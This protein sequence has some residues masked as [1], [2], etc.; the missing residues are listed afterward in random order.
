MPRKPSPRN[1]RDRRNR[2]ADRV[3]CEPLEARRVLTASI[4]DGILSIEG[5]AGDDTIT[6][7]QNALGTIVVTG[8]DG[9]PDGTEFTGVTQVF[10]SLGRG[11]D[12]FETIGNLFSAPP[13][14][15]IGLAVFGGGGNDT[16]IGGNGD[17]RLRGGNNRDTIFGMG[18]DDIIK[19]KRGHD[20]LIG[21]EGDDRLV[22]NAGNDEIHGSGGNDLIRG[23]R[24]DDELFAGL[25]GS[26]VLR[27]H[28][29]SDLFFAFPAHAEDYG[30]GDRNFVDVE[31]N[32]T[33][34]SQPDNTFWLR[35]FSGE[36]PAGRLDPGIVSGL[37]PLVS[38]YGQAAIEQ[39][40]LRLIMDS[41]L[42]QERA[43]FVNSL[44][45]VT[46]QWSPRI[47]ADPAA[48][49]LDEFAQLGADL[50]DVPAPTT[51]VRDA[52]ADW[53]NVLVEGLRQRNDLETAV[54]NWR[55]SD[56]ATQGALFAIDSIFIY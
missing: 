29:G 40:E 50:R 3:F 26:N 31:H 33:N 49:T 8:V 24:G 6:I 28:G 21:G 45:D 38:V 19:G 34:L 36:T 39:A 5:T 27:G 17:D 2:H 42:S 7:T 52:Y 25:G 54:Q 1:R 11:D 46:N 41:L 18:G 43:Q 55:P 37:K 51:E 47:L 9:V 4:E 32:G 13:S 20:L 16:I 48:F 23:G 14:F 56:P 44:V 15:P 12:T 30:P 10:V 22:G 53:V 35:V